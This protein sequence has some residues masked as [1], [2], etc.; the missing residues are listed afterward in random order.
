MKNKA[1]FLAVL[2]VFGLLFSCSDDD[3]T[4]GPVEPVDR[5]LRETQTR[6]L[7]DGIETSRLEESFLS[8]QP[9][10][11]YTFEGSTVVSKVEYKYNSRGS[12]ESLKYYYDTRYEEKENF[13]Y[14]AKN[15][16]I[17]F[18]AEK[19]SAPEMNYYRE[20]DYPSDTIIIEQQKDHL[21]NPLPGG[22]FVYTL[23]ED[24]LIYKVKAENGQVFMAELDGNQIISVSTPNESEYRYTYDEVNLD[25]GDF[26][27]K[28]YQS[29]YGTNLNNAALY[30]SSLLDIP[31]VY[32]D[33]F[34]LSAKSENTMFR[35]DYT[36]DLEGSPLERADYEQEVQTAVTTYLYD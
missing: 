10:I 23:N 1:L 35:Y 29:I 16:L 30:V 21:K 27:K 2:L 14:D 19:V 33:K 24:G 9:Y 18:Y 3:E 32:S 8:G 7:T 31:Q 5:V 11:R 26:Y 15:R 34:L 28:Y 4:S 17:E 22:R 20:F 13:L 12:V 36:L 25:Q 6:V